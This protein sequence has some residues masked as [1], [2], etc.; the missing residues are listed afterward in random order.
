M[1]FP[2]RKQPQRVA[3]AG[4]SVFLAITFAEHLINAPLNP[5]RHE[6]SEY[7]HASAGWLMT[8]GFAAW[9]L[10]LA[11]TSWLV[12][13]RYADRLA[14]TCLALASL[15][16][17]ITA[18]FSTQ[19]SAGHLPPGVSW[20]AVGRLHDIGSG[21]ATLAIFASALLSLRS[22]YPRPVRTCTV[23]LL[24]VAVSADVVLLMIGHDVAGVRQRLLVVSGCLWQLFLL[25]T[26]P[27]TSPPE[28][29]TL[30]D[31]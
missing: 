15:G 21:L 28:G 26:T 13:T 10:S 4:V 7:V 30:S 6:I 9:G 18:C 23:A 11:I 31:S 16:L 19:T 2:G 5:A 14:S 29:P 27:S 25:G 24:T 12:F 17:V 20:N 1:S 3:I 8:V 22:R